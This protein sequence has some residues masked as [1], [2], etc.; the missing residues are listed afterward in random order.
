MTKGLSRSVTALFIMIRR[1]RLN[2][3][4]TVAEEY[5]VLF[6][7]IFCNDFMRWNVGTIPFLHI[8]R[9]RYRTSDKQG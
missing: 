9:T 7:P 2:I 3:R 6:K 8:P 1:L 5:G 4:F